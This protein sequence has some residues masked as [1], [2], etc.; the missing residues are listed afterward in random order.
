MLHGHCGPDSPSHYYPKYRRVT[1]WPGSC[2]ATA[3]GRH[4]LGEVAEEED[5]RFRL[6]S[7]AN[8]MA[9]DEKSGVLC[10]SLLL[11]ES[12]EHQGKERSAPGYRLVD[13]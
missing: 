9:L 6:S 2:R 4:R 8:T 1:E 7:H 3:S 13:R 5:E 11:K 12:L 10:R